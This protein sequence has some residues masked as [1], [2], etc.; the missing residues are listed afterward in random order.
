DSPQNSVRFLSQLK[1]VAADKDSRQLSSSTALAHLGLSKAVNLGLKSA[2]PT[3][4]MLKGHTGSG[5][6]SFGLI[7][8]LLSKKPFAP[9][10]LLLVPHRDLAYQFMHWIELITTAATGDARHSTSVAQVIVRG[11]EGTSFHVSQLCDKAPRGRHAINLSSLR[12]VVVD[13]YRKQ[14]LE[15]KMKRHPSAGKLLLDRI[16]APRVRPDGIV[17]CYPSDWLR[18]QLYQSGW[19]KKGAGMVVK[20]HSEIPEGNIRESDTNAAGINPEAQVVEHCALVFSED[21]S[22]RDVEGSV[23]S[24]HSSEDEEANRREMETWIDLKDGNVPEIPAELSERYPGM[25]LALNPIL[26]EGIASVFATEVPKVALLVLPASA[27]VQR[28]VYDLGVLG[29]NAIALDLIATRRL[30]LPDLT[31]VFIWGVVDANTYLHVSGR[32]GRFRGRGKVISALEDNRGQHQ[33]EEASRYLRL[34]KSIGLT[35]IKFF[36]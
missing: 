10:S 18:Q 26:M 30:D 21:G 34:I 6:Y 33:V 12:S 15:A 27:P 19:F 31:H 32:V 36:N 22:V 29:I 16:Y 20:V 11:S 4:V 3:D 35:P 13:E 7:L 1:H 28:A 5:K 8:A 9:A 2:F 17:A 23:E 25:P 24:K 14:K